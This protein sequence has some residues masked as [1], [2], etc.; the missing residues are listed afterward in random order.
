MKKKLFTLMLS[1][2]LHYINRDK[3]VKEPKDRYQMVNE[4]GKRLT[5]L[6]MYRVMRTEEKVG[7]LGESLK[8]NGFFYMDRETKELLK[9]D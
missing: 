6:Q 9:W 2:A 7:F 5:F 4:N 8:Q 3:E 1:V